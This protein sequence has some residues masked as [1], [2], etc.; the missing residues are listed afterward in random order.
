MK[1]ITGIISLLTILG[2]ILVGCGNSGKSAS[3]EDHG[4]KDIEFPL[5][6]KVSLKFMTQSSPLAPDDPNEKL[7][8][9]RLEEKTG[10]HIDWKN[11]THD[12]FI[13]K[14]NLA[15]SSGDLPDAILDAGFSNYDQTPS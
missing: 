1:K 7:I 6:E 15:L 12:S 11:Y 3:S 4:L 13:E 5:E 8:Y 10:V 14:R 9:K 2:L